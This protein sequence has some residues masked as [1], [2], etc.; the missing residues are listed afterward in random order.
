MAALKKQKSSPKETVT[1]A[2]A[3]ET[4][5]AVT[6]GHVVKPVASPAHKLQQ[7]LQ[8]AGYRSEGYGARQ[9]SNAMLVLSLICVYAL[10]MLMFFG[11]FT[12]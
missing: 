10:S 8:E 4:V 6:D 1:S 9:M 2:A 11:S 12:V 3:T 7:A 5:R